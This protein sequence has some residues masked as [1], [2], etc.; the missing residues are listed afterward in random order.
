M[1]LSDTQLCMLE[2]LCYINSEVAEKAG[3]S[4]FNAIGASCENM[5][6]SQILE[7]FGEEEL[8]AL[9]AKGGDTVNYI[10][11]K[12]WAGIIRY[13]KTSEIKDL[14][15]TDTLNGSD[16]AG[17]LGL[18]FAESADSKEAI[19]AFN[20]TSKKEWGDN[21]EGLNVADTPRQE[22]AYE[23]IESLPYDNITVTGHSKGSNKGM[24][25]AVRSDKVTRCVCFD[26]QGFSNEFIR[27][28][29][30]RIIN[31]AE[32]ITNYSVYTD[33]VHALLFPIPGSVQKYCIGYGISGSGEHHASNSFF[34][35]DENGNIEL[36]NEGN[37]I[38]KETSENESI[39]MLHEFTAF[40][41]NNASDSEKERIVGYLSPLVD[42]VFNEEKITVEEILRDED[43][44]A[45]IIAY[46]AKYM[47]VSGRSTEDIDK[48]L[49]VIG[50]GELN[51][52][53]SYLI[54]QII[55]KDGDEIEKILLSIF[56]NNFLSEY[57]I[58]IYDFWSKINAN[59]AK[60]DASGG[61]GDAKVVSQVDWIYNNA[62]VQL[63]PNIRA[64][65][66]LL[67]DYAARLTRVYKRI[68]DLD[69]R[70]DSLYLKTDKPE[71]LW[72]ILKSDL[73]MKYN[74]KVK[75]CAQYL[76]ETADDFD[77]LERKIS[78]AFSGV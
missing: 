60:I 71:E 27:K 56:A 15:L 7:S 12:E 52:V 69:T 1:V 4:G 5:T 47:Q 75:Y 20:G 67:R 63:N 78:S 46:L 45:L 68:R 36:D 74:M 21:I 57:D 17:T 8:K 42:K 24:Y 22:E 37:P 50:L 72:H 70:M 26:G 39:K 40:V 58:N 44:L 55:D 35:T 59:I 53:V 33:Y 13:L 41:L 19:V 62:Y 73:M 51:S 28:Y 23:Y 2:Q 18:C 66:A 38:F 11:C 9:E 61:Y 6:V 25:V 77:L 43:T 48:L 29:G 76:N 34:K 30:D 3:I 10:S 32:I 49:K 65:T 14:V 54:S 31:R 64:D 16:N